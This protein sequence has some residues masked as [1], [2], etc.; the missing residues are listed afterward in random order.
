M[1]LCKK[2]FP[3]LWRFFI[4]YKLSPWLLLQLY[5]S[6]KNKPKILAVTERWIC[7]STRRVPGLT[8]TNW[9]PTHYVV[10]FTPGGV[11]RAMRSERKGS[12]P[13]EAYNCEPDMMQIGNW[14]NI[15]IYSLPCLQWACVGEQMQLKCQPVNHPRD[16]LKK[17]WRA[18]DLFYFTFQFANF[19][20]FV[21]YLSCSGHQR[22][23]ERTKNHIVCIG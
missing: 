16:N 18:K 21:E 5:A 17:Q 13:W 23:R 1:H 10:S 3:S 20:F 14:K 8:K 19:T 11:S 15:Y 7:D 4:S 12:C 6:A 22:Y 9:A 2:K